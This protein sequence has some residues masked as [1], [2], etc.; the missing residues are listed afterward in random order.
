[1]KLLLHIDSLARGGSQQ[2]LVNL[3]VGM[4]GRSHQVTI[5][6]YGHDNSHAEVLENAGVECVCTGKSHRFDIM[7]I[8][9]LVR[10]IYRIKPD[11]IVAFLQTPSVY[12]EL[13]RLV[14]P[15]TP[16]IVSE[17]AGLLNGQLRSMDKFTAVFHLLASRVN[18][19][20]QSYLDA[21]C[22]FM[23]LLKKRSNVIYNG[24][25]TEY[26]EAGDR[27]LKHYGD[28]ESAISKH[29]GDQDNE[30]VVKLV[31]VAARPC[32]DKGLFV[33]IE[34]LAAVVKS[35]RSNI[36][37]DWIGPCDADHPLVDG[38][39]VAAAK[40][41]IASLGL[42]LYWH[43]RG[44]T[45]DLHRVYETYDALLLPSLHE[46]TP[47][48]MCEAMACGLPVIVTDI[49]DNALLVKHGQQGFVCDVDSAPALARAIEKLCDLTIIA[50][51]DLGRNAH[52]QAKSKFSM[53]KYLD[54]WEKNIHAVMKPVAQ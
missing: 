4:A 24:L 41:S 38:N 22:Q 46:G 16:V 39:E 23:P 12:S 43:W 31:V 14:S 13:A 33:L 21:L 36:R 42:E 17:R 5:V 2:Q 1:V 47:N 35:G 27:M 48:V 54:S 45:R 51:C 20:S 40:S 10:W 49:A 11:C 28:M 44:P 18:T 9:R 29:S 32:K 15:R 8:I 37:L 50:R 34:A 53:D 26:F 19:N 3:A 52:I 6:M 30:G 7:P 25:A